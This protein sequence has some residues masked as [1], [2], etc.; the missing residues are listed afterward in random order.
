MDLVKNGQMPDL[1]EPG[2]KSVTTVVK[3]LQWRKTSDQRVNDSKLLHKNYI[4]QNVHCYT[5]SNMT[6]TAWFTQTVYNM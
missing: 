6:T 3:T 5:M 1:L 4:K 2:S